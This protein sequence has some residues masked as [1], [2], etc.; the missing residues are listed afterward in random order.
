MTCDDR[1]DLVLLRTLG[2]LSGEEEAA[3]RRAIEQECPPLTDVE[4]EAAATLAQIA[5]SLPATAPSDQVRAAF[6]ARVAAEPRTSGAA[7]A[8]TSARPGAAGPVG[9][10]SSSN[11]PSAWTPNVRPTRPSLP[12]PAPAPARS[13]WGMAVVATAAALLAVLVVWAPFHQQLASAR[14]EAETAK[15]DSDSAR[16]HAEQLATRLAAADAELHQTQA[17]LETKSAAVASQMAELK[18]LLATAKEEL[19]K[20]DARLAS[21]ESALQDARR[22]TQHSQ[23]LA[24]AM[25]ARLD[26][27]AKQHQV[28]TELIA[29]TEATMT[30]MRSPQLKI[31]DLAGGATQPKAWARL[32]WDQQRQVWHL[33]AV[34]LAPLPQ[35]KTYELW[36]ITAAQQKIAAGTFTVDAR[37]AGMLVAAIPPNIG[38]LAL[39]AVTDEPA[40]GVVAPTG[41][42]QLLGSL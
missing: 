6:L 31:I 11:G 25:S 10:A 15:H 19:A 26:A 9:A 29:Q 24:T 23:E 32:F 5:L 34:N 41:A 1:S 14:L 18:N 35:G 13:A 39:A 16:Q 20:R 17:S 28:L 3:A 2:G 7:P 40:G 27:L 12:F 33:L 22:D 21:E 4:A 38:V 37:G 42:V 30:A 36:F 8:G